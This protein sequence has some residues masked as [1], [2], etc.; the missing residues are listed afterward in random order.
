MGEDQK[1]LPEQRNGRGYP[2]NNDLGK[3]PTLTPEHLLQVLRRRMELL[4]EPTPAVPRRG[5]LTA[6]QLVRR[7]VTGWLMGPLGYPLVGW[8][9]ALL[10]SPLLLKRMVD[11]VRGRQAVRQGYSTR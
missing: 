7:A 2:R 9:Y 3:T 10:F 11:R 6:R 1:P 5:P 8:V 4:P